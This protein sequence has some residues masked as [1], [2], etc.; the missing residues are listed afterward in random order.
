MKRSGP[1]LTVEVKKI[2]E[3]PSGELPNTL[4]LIQRSLAAA[5]YFGEVPEINRGSTNAN[6]PISKGIPSVTIGRGGKGGNAYSLA[7]WW[8][9]HE[10][11]KAIQL[12]L[13]TFMAEA[14]IDQ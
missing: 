9:D 5:T 3:R 13:L 6:I 1:S 12:A 2:G 8:Y 10:G 4:P 14:G 7:E 11:H